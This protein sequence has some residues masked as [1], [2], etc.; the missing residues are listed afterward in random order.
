MPA[1]EKIFPGKCMHSFLRHIAKIRIGQLRQVQAVPAERCVIVCDVSN[2][3][4]RVLPTSFMNALADIEAGRL[5]DL[6]TAIT[7]APQP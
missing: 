7:Q 6:D 3:E 2:A 5:V 4:P 1:K